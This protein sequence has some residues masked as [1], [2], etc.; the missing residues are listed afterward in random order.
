MLLFWKLVDET[1]ISKPP[2]PNRHHNSTKLWILL[3][4]RADLLYILQYETPCTKIWLIEIIPK[5]VL[6]LFVWECFYPFLLL[7]RLTLAWERVI[8]GK[9]YSVYNHYLLHYAKRR[10]TWSLDTVQDFLIKLGIK[11]C[12]HI[13]RI[14][15]FF[16]KSCHRQAY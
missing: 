1:Q 11:P 12:L 3:S 10:D 4:L 6:Y 2:E 13:L 7:F 5:S 15:I 16:N 8:H 9:K 14:I